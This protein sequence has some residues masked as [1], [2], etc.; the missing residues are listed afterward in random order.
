MSLRSR[1]LLIT[2][3]TCSVALLLSAAAMLA[4]LWQAEKRD[5]HDSLR[6]MAG[7][8]STL[9]SHALAT[10]DSLE[11]PLLPLA[12]T[13]P[14]LQRVCLYD[15]N[16]RLLAGMTVRAGSRDCE[17]EPAESGRIVKAQRFSVSVPLELPEGGAGA[18]VLV[19]DDSVLEQRGSDLL[20]SVVMAFVLSILVA[21]LLAKRLQGIVTRPL[22][23]L[24]DTA[25]RITESNDYATR[26]QHQ[27]AGREIDRL[28]TA[29]NH[30]MRRIDR[31][32]RALTTSERRFRTLTENSPVGIFETNANGGFCYVN[33]RFADI[34]GLPVASVSLVM[35]DMS[36]QFADGESFSQKWL[37]AI[38]SGE[39]FMLAFSRQPAEDLIVTVVGRA[40]PLVDDQGVLAGYLGSL[41]DVTEL[42]L[43]RSKLEHLAFFDPLTNLAN[44]RM[45]ITSIGQEVALAER[46]DYQYALL[47][48]DLDEFKRVNDTLG[49]DA[50]DVLL[51][52]CAERLGSCVR[53]SDVVARMG[54]DE[55]L[56]LLRN[57]RHP[58]EVSTVAARILQSFRNPVVIGSQQVI[59][60]SSIGITLGPLDGRDPQT[61]LKNA[62]LAMYNAKSAGRNA[63]R[64]FDDGMSRALREQLVI[65]HDLREAL[66]E[67]QFQLYFQPQIGMGS[68]HV[69]GVEA[70]VRW[71]HPLNGMM[72]PTRFIPVAETT[73]LIIP[74]GRWVIREACRVAVVLKQSGLFPHL[75]RLSINLSPKQFHDS[76]LLEIFQAA[77]VQYGASP[78]W[79]E[80][81]ITESLLMEDSQRSLG[82]LEQLRRTGVGL[83]V[84]DFGTGYSSLSYLKRFPIDTLKIDRS[85]VMDI[86]GDRSDM[87]I[88]GAVIAMAHKLELRV[89]AE[90]VE[91]EAQLRF[92]EENQCDVFQGYLFARPMPL[93][94][95]LQTRQADRIAPSE[96]LL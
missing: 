23:M 41:T 55:F 91:T 28:V 24:S 14:A 54:G 25:H 32:H 60:T 17:P 56:V 48:L 79:I 42:E 58:E 22:D 44:R 29:F 63:W 75:Q 37:K 93:D 85:F 3:V 31:E 67:S 83:A 59:V 92:L 74:L 64:F 18:L 36:L 82:I 70:L 46:G 57:I 9:A 27:D 40:M 5:S 15:I 7:V 12:R 73:G 77:L 21:Y 71:H 34:I 4:V 20:I 66:A 50:G 52:V 8:M 89:V 96:P 72:H 35:A 45:I 13:L 95:L 30:M 62:D 80:F 78:E 1:I 49:H 65:E 86:P 43:T 87:E 90:G 10:G 33:E 53:P 88:A 81:E 61:L 2:L 84:D 11:P 19:S 51:K 39:D 6:V 47:M 94:T 69:V 38:Q 68:Y 16:S 26:A 76:K